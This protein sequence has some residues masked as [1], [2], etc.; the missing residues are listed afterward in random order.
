MHLESWQWV[1]GAVAAAFIGITKTGIPGAGIL[2]VSVLA[3]AFGGL[4]SIGIMLPMLIYADVFAV[5]WY[6]RHTQWDKLVGLLPGVVVG[7]ALGGIALWMTGKVNGSKDVLAKVIGVLT[8]VMLGIHLLRGRLGDRL[9]P[10]SPVGV[11][12]TG[13]AAGFTTMVSNA[14]GAIMNIYMAAHRVSKE[15]FIGTLAWYFLIVNLSKVPVYIGLSVA[16]PKNPVMTVDT[17]VFTLMMIP[18][19]VVGVYIGKWILPR[20][21]QESFEAIVLTLAAVTA[22]M[23][24]I[25]W[26]PKPAPTK[27]T[28]PRT[29]FVASEAERSGAAEVCPEH[30]EGPGPRDPLPSPQHPIP[31][32][33]HLGVNAP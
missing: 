9:T 15:Q 10:T 28:K 31:N 8:L 22:I 25:G 23:L 30:V 18:A 13:V 4:S 19:I 1:V 16:N 2:V 11:V 5:A 17:F 7:L 21:S 3:M 20:F 26:P 6:R 14:A 12:A 27:E 33:Q 24:I 29:S 32:T